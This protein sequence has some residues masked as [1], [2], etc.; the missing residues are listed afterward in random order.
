MAERYLFF[1]PSSWRFG[2]RPRSGDSFVVCRVPDGPAD[3]NTVLLDERALT[4]NEYWHLRADGTVL[5]HGKHAGCA[6]S[7]MTVGAELAA[8]L[9]GESAAP[10]FATTETGDVIRFFAQMRTGPRDVLAMWCGEWVAPDPA[11]E[12]GLR[13]AQVLPLGLRKI[14]ANR[15]FLNNYQRCLRKF[16]PDTEIEHKL[17]LASDVDVYGLAVHFRNLVGGAVFPDYVWEYGNDFEQWDFDNRLYEVSGPPEEAGYVSFMPDPHGTVGVK[18]KWFTADAVERRET[19]WVSVRL[20]GS[21]AEY[22]RRRFGVVGDYL[23]AFRRIR[24]DIQLESLSTG[25]I[26]VLTIDRCRFE[27]D[28][29][30][31]LCQLEVE[32]W[33]SRTLRTSAAATLRAELR[34]IVDAAKAE[35]DR[36]GID[37]V[38]SPLSKSTYMR[39]LRDRTDGRGALAAEV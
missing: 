19:R 11:A 17:T 6:L 35:L 14:E 29:W 5:R 13:L 4:G 12:H 10:L 7:R 38:E 15:H 24:F 34:Q 2:A 37:H 18:R 39:R 8:L 33:R 25:N 31:D 28:D 1:C 36:L 16:E 27:R 22:I 3:V 20:A 26:H 30:P 23:G 9:P 32:Y 21:E